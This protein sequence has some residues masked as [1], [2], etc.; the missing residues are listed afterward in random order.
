MQPV[1][2]GTASERH[3]CTCFCHET[4]CHEKRVGTARSTAVRHT[5]IHQETCATR[6]V[7]GYPR[8]VQYHGPVCAG[9]I[10]PPPPAAIGAHGCIHAYKTDASLAKQPAQPAQH[11]LQ[12]PVAYLLHPLFRVAARDRPRS[13][14]GTCFTRYSL[15][16]SR[17]A[18]RVFRSQRII[19][20]VLAHF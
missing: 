6:E 16:D 2:Q 7:D 3:T 14:P 11:P 9:L 4:R 19:Q 18:F 5:H 10:N 12:R 20:S 8:Q 17:R 15:D 13:P 1:T